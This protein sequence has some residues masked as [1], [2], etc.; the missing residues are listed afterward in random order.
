MP[1][2]N[3]HEEK[4]RSIERVLP[5]LNELQANHWDWIAVLAFYAALHWL[6]AYLAYQ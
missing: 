1:A 5:V 2:Q 3:A 4:A 6:D